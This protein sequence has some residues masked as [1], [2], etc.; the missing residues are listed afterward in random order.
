MRRSGCAGC[1]SAKASPRC[2]AAT[3]SSTPSSSCASSAA[4]S[5]CCASIS[6]TCPTT[7]CSPACS[8]TTPRVLPEHDVVLFSDYGKGGLTH[9]PR[10]IEL[11]R[12]AAKPVLVDPKGG[13]Y[14][15]Y[16]GASVITPNRAELSAGDRRLE[17]SEAACA[18]GSQQLRQR[19]DLGALVLTR[20]EEGMALFDAAGDVEVP[21]NAR[22]VFDVTGRRRHGDRD[23]GRAARLR[24][25]AARGDAAGEPCRRHRRRQVRHRRRALRRVVSR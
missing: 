17:Q 19:F 13:D 12:A 21:A 23:A 4:R 7:R 15:R 9:I 20:S 11:A 14:A 16:A 1:S 10:M 25:R 18:S 8:T 5:S 22:E 3:R 24:R 2:S 6:R